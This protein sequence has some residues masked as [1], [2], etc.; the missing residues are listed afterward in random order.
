M[1]LIDSHCHIHESE[2]FPDVAEQESAYQRA[3]DAGVA[4][5]CV[6]TSEKASREALDFVSSHDDT[7]AILGVHPHEAKDG[8]AAIG[9]ILARCMTSE[10]ASARQEPVSATP[11]VPAELASLKQSSARQEVP[12]PDSWACADV[13]GAMQRANPMKIVGIGEIGL[14]YYYNNSPRDVQIAVLEQQLQW[15]MDY[16]LPVSFHVRE[17][18]AD[19]W[20][21]FDNF[22]GI[23]GVLHSFTD[24]Q[25]NLD[26]GFSRGL[27]VGVNGISTFTKDA[28]QQQL[29]AGIPLEKMLLETDAPFLT[30]APLR[31]KMN[32]PSYVGR[33][34]EHAA[35][36]RGVSVDAVS[37]TTT[38][39]TRRLFVI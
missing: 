15:A 21:I 29:F 20:P 16:D 38:D 25:A 4:I 36:L 22:H 24:A 23:R 35:A 1:K 17:A 12:S 28:A 5:V 11:W 32:E 10:T 30:P 2:F 18:F 6:A 26:E 7:W 39:N 3:I 9:E 34:A 37:R 33:V 27:Y 31:G 19:F 8:C 13:S 14:D